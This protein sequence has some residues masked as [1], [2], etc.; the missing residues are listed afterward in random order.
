MKTYKMKTYRFLS[1]F[2]AFLLLNACNDSFLE[3]YPIEQQ[4]EAT[5]FKTYDN[6]KTYSWSLYSC[7]TDGSFMQYWMTAVGGWGPYNGDFLAG[8]LTETLWDYD[9]NPYRAQTAIVPTAGGD[10]GW[11]FMFLRK[12][13]LML[14]NIDRSEMTD[15]EKAHWRSV[16]YFFHAYKYVELI[17]RF[18]DVPWVDHVVGSDETDIIYGPR[19]PRKEV[20]GKVLAELQYAEKN[21]KPAGDGDNTINVNVVRALMSRFCLFE[22]TWRIYHELGDAEPYLDECIRVS[23]ELMTTFPEVDS[24]Y[25]NLMNSDNLSTY[26]G[27]ILYKEFVRDLLTNGI[28]YNER[29]A[30]G[31]FEMHKATVEMYL[32]SDGKS[33]S[34]SPLYAGD[35]TMYDEFRNRDY[36]LLLQVT[37]PFFMTTGYNLDFTPNGQSNGLVYNNAGVDKQEYVN[38]IKTICPSATSKRLPVFNWSGA[39]NWMS[40]NVKGPGQGPMA[41]HTGYYMWRHYNLWDANSNQAALN[42]CDKP[43]FHIEE[44]LL[45]YA[46]AKFERGQFN[47][48]VADVSIN[49]LR[50]RVNVADMLVAD[51]NNSFDPRRDPTVNPVLW[52]IR[53]E[54]IVELM[55]EGFGF[56]DIRRWKKGP[57]FINQDIMGVYV[58]TAEFSGNAGSVNAWRALQLVDR[59]FNPATNEGYLKVFPNPVNEG[60]G[61]LDKYYLF[62][63]PS[64]DKVL[65]PQLDQNPD[66]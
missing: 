24:N 53:R 65:N 5:A 4:T 66:W 3:K 63:I 54:R 39:M 40:P 17:S 44:V 27:I 47:Q 21:I 29:T 60:K 26:K 46:E 64:D 8:Y 18:G 33:I 15:A 51:I 41:S 35:E 62:P 13:C 9:T 32:C 45:N 10:V 34:T 61:W 37:P 2:A 30:Q 36:R 38:L 25:D 52:E 49:K 20:A 50:K 1:I 14:D 43:I 12:C 56:Q 19:S 48:S 22:G 28:G 42:T 57:W 7:F 23:E 6:F 55:S 11:G 31:R 58:K 59:N 16:G